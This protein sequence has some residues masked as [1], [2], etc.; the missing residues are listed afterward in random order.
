MAARFK[1]KVHRGKGAG[2][3]DDVLA[4]ADLFPQF[5]G[6]AGFPE[7]TDS[8]AYEPVQRLLAI[9]TSDGRVKVIGREGV[10]CTFR[11][12][13]SQT[14]TKHIQFLRGK[15]AILRITQ[16][17]DA[18]LWGVAE[19]SVL[20]SIP[21]V[22]AVMAVAVMHNDPYVL[23]GC[24]SG[25]I[26]VAALVD[27]SGEPA[28]GAREVR[29]ISMTPYEVSAETL[30]AEGAVVTLAVHSQ[31][32]QHRLLAVHSESGACIW[33]LR[34]QT[35]LAKASNCTASS[36]EASGSDESI[37]AEEVGNATA[38]CWIGRHGTHFA[39]GHERGDILIWGIPKA[40][41]QD[42]TLPVAPMPAS[43]LA[44][45]RV[46][47]EPALASAIRSL[48]FVSGGNGGQSRLLVFGGQGADQPDV[49]T[50]L[51]LKPAAAEG[52]AAHEAHSLPWFGAI[53]GFSL[54]SP[55]GS[56]LESDDPAA[57]IVL[58][59]GGQ[60]MV[61]DLVSFTPVPLSLPFQELPPVTVSSFVASASET[62]PDGAVL[63]TTAP[64]GLTL[65]RLR[66]TRAHGA[67]L[68][69]SISKKG[70]AWRWRWVFAGGAPPQRPAG[71]AGACD[72]YLTGHR[73][74]R[75]RVWDMTSNVPD[76]LATVPFD[77]G[78]AGGRLREVTAL[79]V[80]TTS[81]LLVVGHEKGETRVYQFSASRQ[82]VACCTLD[83]REAPSQSQL[84][85][86]PGFQCI[87]LTSLH[88]GSITALALASRA[89]WLAQGDDTGELAVLDLGQ[90]AMLYRKQLTDQPLTALSFGLQAPQLAKTRSMSM[91]KG[92][93]ADTGEARLSLFISTVDCSMLV[94]DAE[95]GEGGGKEAWLRPKNTCQA[96]SLTLLDAA[97]APL[98]AFSGPAV[99]PWAANNAPP[100]AAQPEPESSRS[101]GD[102]QAQEAASTS[103]EEGAASR[104]GLTAADLELHQS[105]E[106]E[107]LPSMLSSN[108]AAL[109]T[110]A[111]SEAGADLASP[112]YTSRSAL[113][114]GAHKAE[115]DAS[116]EEFQDSSSASEDEDM[117][118]A[119]AVAAVEA[120]EMEKKKGGKLKA[121]KKNKARKAPEPTASQRHDEADKAAL[122]KPAAGDKPGA[123]P[124][125][126]TQ[127]VGSPPDKKGVL[128][129]WTSRQ[130]VTSAPAS[131]TGH[132]AD[133]PVGGMP[134]LNM[135]RGPASQ[136]GS[137]VSSPM[138]SA[139][140]PSW[141]RAASS[142][143]SEQSEADG[144]ASPCA[145]HVLICT[146]NYLR[147]YSADGVR[148]G[149]RTTAKKAY[150][151]ETLGFA[152]AFQSCHGPGVACITRSANV[153]VYSLPGLERLAGASLS[154]CLQ[155][156]WTWNGDSHLLAR[157]H[158]ICAAAP[159]GQ[160]ALVGPGG[161][162]ARL[163]LVK[164]TQPPARPTSLYD[165]DLALAAAAAA[166]AVADASEREGQQQKQDFD[167]SR[168][169]MAPRAEA[170]RADSG[171]AAL[172]AKGFGAFFT[173]V[174]DVATKVVDDANKEFSKVQQNLKHLPADLDKFGKDIM[175]K[176]NPFERPK[177]PPP[178]P[179]H[180]LFAKELKLQS[181][182]SPTSPT[183]PASTSARSS[184]SFK[185][186]Q[187]QPAVSSPTGKA[188]APK[189]RST[190]SEELEI[191]DF[192]QVAGPAESDPG[193]AELFRGASR[194][195]GAGK[196]GMRT[197][198]E[199]RAAYG[200]A[201]AK[202]ANEVGSLMAENRD[203]LMER[204]EKLSRLQDKTDALEND[205][206]D[207]ATMARKLAEQQTNRKWWQL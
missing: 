106:A 64:H 11:H 119:A 66:G 151:E 112:A 136:P 169:A 5:L 1:H 80:C 171:D 166:K 154:A 206:A 50:L 17:G 86:P 141:G 34:Y 8:L 109:S 160:L 134:A 167:A 21:C 59:E 196:P 63:P 198:A 19:E 9:G 89:C 41:V 197:A 195:S 31:G 72:L 128:G 101:T 174:K 104:S 75:V 164:G 88:T 117:L 94:V 93:E 146:D 7:A 163:A 186:P 178:P 144:R 181:T 138:N 148:Q 172:R 54:V 22:D 131:D 202:R 4:E 150:M 108:L 71:A 173:Q 76:L 122:A 124:V 33:D 140:S 159:D 37:S 58:T 113:S 207:F 205:A 85:Q 14:A 47:P 68:T 165:W 153:V 191:D 180:E 18:Q 199:I 115:S 62:G 87:L 35:V 110:K 30:N 158:H 188:E 79:Q 200:R 52:E 83:R 129:R 190:L 56:I 189:G 77:S 116:D 82:Q 201:P 28:V 147:L 143:L 73:D 3:A 90:P 60:L 61:H 100:P 130:H 69:T 15:G 16:E 12:S 149:D 55:E 10:E 24:Q 6:H 132:A 204:G 179:L 97:G 70:T 40:A 49:L 139:V 29:S 45:L 51:P 39:T 32:E 142:A 48:A 192:E 162:V 111:R 98:P 25:D 53:K 103:T 194:P 126:A 123:K 65:D 102:Q 118:L 92:R 137:N 182:D 203:K 121:S 152:A 84:S 193:R 44:K 99:L 157:L 46:V 120:K 13:S 185:R 38:A 107:Q 26:Q 43:L 91:D 27:A 183:S 81:G 133:L 135:A 161:E 127:A 145:T 2:L 95:R 184:V 155:F 168:M 177:P 42:D 175:A 125:A 78:G 176:R 57:I 23:L 67:S 156:P 105:Q 187:G 114:A 96:L 74:G 20:D 170:G 36:S